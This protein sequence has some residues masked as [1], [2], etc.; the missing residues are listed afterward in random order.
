MSSMKR[1]HTNHGG[2]IKMPLV[3]SYPSRKEW[4]KACWEML[5][6]SPQSL[7]YIVTPYERRNI[8]LRAAVV[9]RLED[10]RS[11]RE[12]G[13]ELWL[14]SQTISTIKKGVRENA[15]RSYAGRGERKKKV[16][17]VSRSPRRKFRRGAPH[18]TKY[19]IV[20]Y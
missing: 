13:R 3:S 10:R 9:H 7:D 19:G 5:L 15:Y 14:S 11:Y 20:Y 6:A 4:E 17:S 2:R 12:I 16:Y 18:K 8:V 1:S